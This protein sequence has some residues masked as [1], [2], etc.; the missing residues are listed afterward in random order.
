MAGS[1]AAPPFRGQAAGSGRPWRGRG[2]AGRGSRGRYAVPCTAGKLWALLTPALLAGARGLGVT[3]F[4]A[5]QLSVLSSGASRVRV[6]GAWLRRPFTLEATVRA[7]SAVVSQP[8]TFFRSAS[9][10]A[11]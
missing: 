5:L 6:C 11:Q 2:R 9:V 1:S 8:T 7:I 10:T 3:S 4:P